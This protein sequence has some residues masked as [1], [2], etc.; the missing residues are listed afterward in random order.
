MLSIGRGIHHKYRNQLFLRID[1]EN[2][3]GSLALIELADFQKEVEVVLHQSVGI[4][5]KGM[6]F[7]VFREVRKVGSEIPFI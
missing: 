2:C 1:P 7:L 3:P 5:G 4:E 6:F